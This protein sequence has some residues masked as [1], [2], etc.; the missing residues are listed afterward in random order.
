MC[1]KD[2]FFYK[3]GAKVG[4]LFEQIPNYFKYFLPLATSKFFFRIVTI[5]YQCTVFIFRDFHY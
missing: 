5:R 3:S 1:L 2:C 4:L